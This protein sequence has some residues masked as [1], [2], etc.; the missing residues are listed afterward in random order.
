ME[1]G[2][3]SGAA[4]DGV[5]EQ[6]SGVKKKSRFRI[7][8]RFRKKKEAP[9]TGA[10][11]AQQELPVMPE[12]AAEPPGEEKKPKK[13]K[14]IKQPKPPKEKKVKPPKP[15]K[16]LKSPKEKK[17]AKQPPPGKDGEGGKKK[18]L[19]VLV[20]ALAAGGAGVALGIVGLL[21][22]TGV[23]GAPPTP[24]EIL[25]KAAEYMLAEDYEKAAAQ[26][27]KIIAIQDEVPAGL[28]AEAY[29]GQ[30]S[31]CVFQEKTAE[32]I[33]TFETG[34]NRTGDERLRQRL[35]ELTKPPEAEEGSP[36][37]PEPIP[38][39]P[40]VWA[41]PAFERMART[42]IGKVSGPVY[43]GDLTGITQLKIVG[44]THAVAN[45]ALNTL[46]YADYYEV[47]GT[48]YDQRG[49][50]ASLADA[51]HFP[52]LE[53]LIVAY[54]HITELS[55]VESLSKLKQLGLYC[56][57]ITDISAV[58]GLRGLEY[59]LLYNNQISDISPLSGLTALT[60][61]WLRHN[62]ISDVSPLE[63][64][65]NLQEL[66]VTGNQIADISMLGGLKA[67]RFLY[68][69]DNQVGDIGVVADLPALTDISFQG[70]PVTDYAPA[71]G[72]ANV[73]QPYTSGVQ[74]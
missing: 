72:I 26:Y 53:R 67:L 18:K 19:P 57:D 46:N 14:K 50:I 9:I 48:V 49:E 64:L 74:G 12:P 51:K 33:L 35:E 6:A 1:K 47:D 16:P 21:F 38:Q 66:F 40:I 17:P 4:G 44:G 69:E 36:A 20:I 41:D 56:N 29:L 24:E 3:D 27:E 54:N 32:A 15:P 30:G 5:G 28:L 13:E 68:A 59:L 63:G 8:F 52:N 60:S 31:I 25:A 7:T 55:G 22:F 39:D 11:E 58:S 70:N 45:A 34:W 23:L 62:Q 42:A 61:L 65:V 71:E 43:P 73:N 10:A 37:E 2:K